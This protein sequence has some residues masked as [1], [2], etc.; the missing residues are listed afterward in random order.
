L[1][2]SELG[3]LSIAERVSNKFKYKMWALL[4]DGKHKHSIMKNKNPVSS[5]NK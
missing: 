1:N 4:I 3:N 5:S 2:D